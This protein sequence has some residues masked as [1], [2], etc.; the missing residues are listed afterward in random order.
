MVSGGAWSTVTTLT[1]NATSYSNTGLAASTTYDYRVVAFNAVG[2]GADSNTA[3]ATT[4]SE[5]G[6]NGGGG[7]NTTIQT[8]NVTTLNIQ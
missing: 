8:L 7:S 6:G 3:S 2:D 1:Q 4:Q 5:G